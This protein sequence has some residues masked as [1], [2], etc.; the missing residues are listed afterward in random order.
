MPFFVVAGVSGRP[1]VKAPG[2]DW[3]WWRARILGGRT[4]HYGRMSLRMEPYDFKP[5]R[6]DGQGFDWP[7]SYE[8]PAPYYDKA[9]ELVGVLGTNDIPF[10]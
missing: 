5:C 7:I 9:E 8:D 4:N 1:Y 3:H 2:S 6:R 10:T